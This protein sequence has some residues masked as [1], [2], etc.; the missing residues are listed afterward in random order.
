M[1][2]E[3]HVGY[4][5]SIDAAFGQ[6]FEAGGGEHQRPP[7]HP[8]TIMVCKIRIAG[9]RHGSFSSGMNGSL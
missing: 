6:M 4:V 1:T 7:Q 2:A 9:K 5:I 3:D 8:H